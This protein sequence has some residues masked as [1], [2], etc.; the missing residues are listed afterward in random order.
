MGTKKETIYFIGVKGVG[1]TMLAQFL[2]AAG[3]KVSGSD[4]KEV[5]LTDS[6][7]KKAG[8][9]VLSPFSARHLPAKIDRII[10]SSAYNIQNNPELAFIKRQP[11][12]FKKVPLLSYA[13]ALAKVFNDHFGLAVCGSHGKT[14]ISAWLGYVL[15]RAGLKPN[16]LVGS[17]V[18]QFKGSAL[19]GQSKYFVAEVDEYQ[20]KLKYFQPRGV[21]LTNIEFDHPDF[22]KTAAAY[23]QVF[24][25]FIKKIPQAGWLVTSAGDPET[26]KIK[27]ACRGQI[28]SVGLSGADWPDYLATNIKEQGSY[29]IFHVRYKGK[30]LGEFKVRLIGVHNVSNALMVIAAAA[31][32][33]VKIPAI[34]K[35][36]SGF[37]GTARRAQI[38]GKYRGAL[39]IDDYAHHPTEVKAT[40]K[41]VREHYRGKNIITVFHPHTY[42]RTKALFKD[43]VAS[44][45]NTDELI[46]LDIYGSA[47]E[48]QG[49]VSSAQLAAAIRRRNKMTG[50]RQAVRHIP[51]LKAATKYLRSQLGSGDLLLLMGA[52]DVFRAGENLIKG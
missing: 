24:A 7:L 22:F 37:K 20:N 28:I 43:F 35:A 32:L 51:T 18:P 42:T 13:E 9:K 36:L 30:D 49:G 17:S 52:G 4:I 25:D 46:I 11:E 8:V 50:R 10:Y 38:L 2:A 31:K 19:F 44:F 16:V 33:G 12:R 21:V 5:F 47:R 29:Q 14:T 15:L 26:K 39:I 41:A 3:H 45:P 40:L 23:R 27:R 6:V 34:K 1:M 48:K